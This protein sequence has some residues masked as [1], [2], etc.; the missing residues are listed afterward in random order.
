MMAFLVLAT[1][2]II[3][4][5]FAP[6]AFREE[7][8]S[9]GLDSTEKDTG[10]DRIELWKVGWKA[11][12]DN[13]ILGVGQGNIPIVISRYQYNQ[14]GESHWKRDMWG[15]ALHSVY[16]TLLS[17]LG[18]VGTLIVGF[19]GKEVVVKFKRIKKI[20]HQQSSA[21]ALQLSNLNRALMTSFFG[22][23][24]T[25]VFLSVLYY[26][27]AWNIAALLL[28]L[29]LIAMRLDPTSGNSSNRNGAGYAVGTPDKSRT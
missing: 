6:P 20:C 17:E 5:S 2:A 7:I 21:E 1:I 28:A 24:V 26:P 12:A 29:H 14:D 19:M 4:W 27:P 22:F 15:R 25:G 3:G 13:P 11:F 10:K 18:L 16:M 8:A 9:I 23:L